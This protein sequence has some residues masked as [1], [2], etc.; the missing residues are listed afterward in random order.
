MRNRLE[1][2]LLGLLGKAGLL[3]DLE[4]AD[5][6]V[7]HLATTPGAADLGVLVELSLEARLVLGEGA[8]VGGLDLGEG[9]DG[10]V[11]LVDEGAEA[12]LALDDAVRDVHLA[13]QGREED[14]ELDRVD[15]V[16]DDDK[17]GLLV[18]NEL[19]DCRSRRRGTV[20]GQ[21]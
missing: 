18:L 1:V 15:V 13:A 4:L 12:A 14:D 21:P 19:G 20:S 11:L 5:G 7:A 10:S 8:G 6:L 3:A 9:D 2:G 16:S 17:L